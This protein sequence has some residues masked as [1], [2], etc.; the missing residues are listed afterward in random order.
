M[1]K[2]DP[3]ERISESI[4]EVPVPH[5]PK[6]TVEV[7]NRDQFLDVPVVRRSA[8]FSVSRGLPEQG[9]TAFC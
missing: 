8:G 4:V 3:Q 2:R 7:M 9:S 1:M 6:E 5:F